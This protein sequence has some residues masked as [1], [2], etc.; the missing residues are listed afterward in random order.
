MAFS[1]IL[2]HRHIVALKQRQRRRDDLMLQGRIVR[3]AQ[4]ETEFVRHKQRA[5]RTNDIGDFVQQ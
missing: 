3:C 2:D 1:E 5:W 4:R